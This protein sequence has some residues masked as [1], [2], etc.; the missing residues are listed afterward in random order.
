MNG[1]ATATHTATTEIANS[2]GFDNIGTST[3][4]HEYNETC[5]LKKGLAARASLPSLSF[6]PFHS[7]QHPTGI[8]KGHVATFQ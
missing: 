3:A 7:S 5:V 8:R 1:M 2:P 4:L 6:T